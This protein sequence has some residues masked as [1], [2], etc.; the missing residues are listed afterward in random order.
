M[1][2][3][4]RPFIVASEEARSTP[5]SPSLLHLIPPAWL[6]QRYGTFT[7]RVRVFRDS[8]LQKAVFAISVKTALCSPEIPRQKG[9]CKNDSFRYAQRFV[10]E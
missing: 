6:C 5:L 3:W 8:V 2:D 4:P 1:P 7:Q 9:I 10:R